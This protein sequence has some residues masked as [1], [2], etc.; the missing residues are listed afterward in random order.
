ML[1]IVIIVMAVG[2]VSRLAREKGR[3]P[4]LY[5]F[6][7]VVASLMLGTLGTVL[8]A[9][10]GE[11]MGIVMGGVII[12]EVVRH[13]PRKPKKIQVFC[14]LCGLKQDWVENG[15]CRECKAPLHR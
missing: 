11:I 14:P 10:L 15:V 12:E 13:L 6:L 4:F 9:D 2:I 1:E 8:L 5:G 3:D 7:T